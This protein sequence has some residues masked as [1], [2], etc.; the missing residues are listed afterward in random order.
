[1]VTTSHPT[2]PLAI[3]RFYRSFWQLL[4]QYPHHLSLLITL[5]IN[6][7]ITLSLV[8]YPNITIAA[9]VVT[10]HLGGTIRS[11]LPYGALPSSS[12]KTTLSLLASSPEK[13]LIKV[14]NIL[15]VYPNTPSQS[16]TGT[17][18][19]PNL[20]HPRDL[21]LFLSLGP[22]R[23][24]PREQSNIRERNC[25]ESYRS[26]WVNS[27]KTTTCFTTTATTAFEWEQ[28]QQQ[29]QQ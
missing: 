27:G 7:S 4:L 14:W 23:S 16:T 25:W 20:T 28:Q 9:S 2:I 17:P 21:Y 22:I 15:S 6:L 8:L 19:R 13:K 12:S 24:H 3:R 10:E 29:Q 5:S 11:S 26:T 1:M 18:S